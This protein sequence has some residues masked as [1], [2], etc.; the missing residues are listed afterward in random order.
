MS[1]AVVAVVPAFD[2]DDGFRGRLAVLA[3]QVAAVVVVDDGSTVPVQRPSALG[4]VVLVRQT[5]GGIAAA[6]NAGIRRAMVDHPDAEFVLTMDQDSTL[7]DDYVHEAVDIAHRASAAGL[8]VAAVAAGSHNGIEAAATGDVHGFRVALE[9]AQSGM[10]LPVDSLR[11]N[12]LFDASLVIDA[13]ETDWVLRARRRGEHVVLAPG[14]DMVHAVGDSHPIRLAGRP[15]RIGGRERRY[16]HH[17]ALRRYYITR[18]RLLVYPRSFRGARSWVVSDTIAEA[19]TLA[20]C[21]VF[22]PGRTRQAAAAVIGA[23][24][25]I[26]GRRGKPS[27]RWHGLLGVRTDA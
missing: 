13:V 20:L 9:V 14:A 24:D 4:T 19:R 16:S 11:R 27:R 1:N 21:L 26:R 18:N 3:A 7:H 8:V 17:S 15:L 6:I 12:G 22:G 23:V 5:N 10:L 2:P 25:G